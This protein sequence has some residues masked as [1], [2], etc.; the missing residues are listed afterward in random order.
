MYFTAFVFILFPL[1]ASN[2]DIFAGGRIISLKMLEFLF[3]TDLNIKV[4]LLPI[5]LDYN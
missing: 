5:I 2:I 4:I 1:F 3:L